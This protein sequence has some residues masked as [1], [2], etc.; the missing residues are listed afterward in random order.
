MLPT[1]RGAI[2]FLSRTGDSASLCRFE[3]DFLVLAQLNRCTLEFRVRIDSRGGCIY[4]WM[5]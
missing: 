1:S 5:S 4:I 3:S 2:A